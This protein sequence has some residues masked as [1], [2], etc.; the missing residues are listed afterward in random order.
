[1]SKSRWIKVLL[2]AIAILLAG[3]TA[4]AQDVTASITGT[5]S[6]SSKAAVAGA[7]ITATDTARGLALTALTSADGTYY[8]N[9]IPVGT[10]NIRVEMTGF[11]AALQSGITLVLNQTARLDFELQVGQITQTVEV[12]GGEPV[13][14]TDS[15]QVSTIIDARTN[16]N[17]PLATRNYVQLTLLA[18]GSV[19]PNPMSFNNGDNTANG[20]RPYI[21]GNREQ[22]NNFLLDGVDNNQVSDNL[23]GYTPTPDAI[24]EFNLITSNASAE[25]GNFQGGIVSAT[26]KSGTNDFHGDA[27]EF[28]RNDKLNANQ[29]E[30]KINPAGELPRAGL[31]W[32]MF[33]GTLGGAAIKNKLFFFVDY[34]GQ[35]FDHPNTSQNFTVF[36]AAERGGDFG[37]LCSQG[38]DANGICKDTTTY[39][40]TS[41]LGHT[42]VANQLYD[43]NSLPAGCNR[44]GAVNPCPQ[45]LPFKDNVIPTN[46]INP[47]AQALFGSAFYP[48]P[49][50]ANATNN[51]VYQTAQSFNADQ[52]DVKV[53]YAVSDKER[54]SWRFSRAFQSNPQTNNLPVIGVSFGDAPIYN[55]SIDWTRSLLPT[56]VNDL[57][58]GW[59]HVT[60]NS[61]A[62]FD[63]AV[64]ALGETLGIPGSNPNG[65]AGLL[66]I[67]FYGG[68][69][70]GL[71][72]GTVSNIGNTLTN[73][74]FNDQVYQLDEGLVWTRGRHT[75]HLGFQ[76]WKQSIKTFYTGNSG[77]LGAAVFSTTFTADPTNGGAATGSGLA[78]FFLG[79]PDNFGRG[80]SS[81]G[82]I[83]SSKIFAGFAQDD[84]RLTNRLTLN[85]GLRYEAHTPWVESND[86]QVNFGL[87]SGEVEFA[88]VAGSSRG[89]YNTHYGGLDFQ[90]R[91]G[92]AWTP[93]LLGQSTV[94]RGA[95]T[96]SSYMEGTG[97]NLRLTLNPPFSPA[98]F[99]TQYSGGLPASTIDQG[100]LAPPAVDPSCPDLDCFSGALIRLWD[101]NVQPAI[102]QQW[103]LTLQRQFW[104]NTT[105]Q[106][107]YVGQHSTHLMVPMPYAQRQ[108]NADG[109]V[110][111]SIYIAGNPNLSSKIS[112]ISGTASIGNQRYDALQ[113][114]L[115]KQMRNGLQYQI[116]YTYSKCMTDSIGYYG[117][118]G[119]LAS[120]TSP[121]FQDIYNQK[122]EWGPCYFDATHVV[123]GYAVYELPF[124]RGKR[125]GKDMNRL[126]NLVAGGWSVSP[127]V[128]W[129]TGFPLTIVDGNNN[130]LN[131][132]V[133]SRGV[134]ADCVA[135]PS[136]LGNQPAAA[137]FGG[138]VFFFDKNSYVPSQPTQFGTCGVGT[139]RGPRY[140]N[141]DVSLHK[142]FKISESKSIQFRSDFLN[143][144]NQVNLNAPNTNIDLSATS[145]TGLIQSSQ[146]ARN[147]QFALKF[148]Y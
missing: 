88:G 22:A 61:G 13:L 106:I 85:L 35:R 32:N 48:A 77:E 111:P 74:D 34:Q 64:G 143:A 140:G 75:W 60:L 78:D 129:H 68:Q 8:I 130:F 101:P 41:G 18:P 115:Q 141:L 109:T 76:F 112:Q 94:I 2:L 62:T 114:V 10:Y 142:D 147:I 104:S 7:K 6:D 93:A 20:G 21:N 71:G 52:G 120:P 29:W 56:L 1:M 72:T 19:T 15:T 146:A 50:N 107:G 57:R 145:T 92:F 102:S 31:R 3:G 121:Y 66:G 42:V 63:P 86:R 82:W 17:L 110:S 100:I 59:N 127:I 118:F 83:Q 51:Y 131:N 135:P 25:F 116:A 11:Q 148:Y 119:A 97:T 124:G 4:D 36:S 45:P 44:T 65:V 39:T 73:Q 113:A 49:L 38:F 28:F 33:G 37:A 5:V 133:G 30:N 81:G 69:P 123:S 53:D 40:D 139:V 137:D 134:R 98:E 27:W 126:L 125:F 80:I 95:Y 54:V 99:L 138:G 136:Y 12:T 108:L 23:L 70:S 43:P 47:V 90:P 26:I 46:R 84:W 14:Q 79:L 24:Q 132:E 122:A 9:R 55:T 58:F 91:I 117:S 89:L 67:G 128:S 105:L 144:F 16:D 87:L 103:N 96:V